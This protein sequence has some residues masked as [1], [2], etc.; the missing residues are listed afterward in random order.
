[1]QGNH[2]GAIHDC[3]AAISRT[4]APAEA[5]LGRTITWVDLGDAGRAIED[6]DAVVK[7]GVNVGAAYSY[8][9][10]ARL[11]ALDFAGAERDGRLGVEAAPTSAENWNVLAVAQLLQG[12]A[13]DALVTATTAATLGDAYALA[14]NTLGVARCVGGDF[15]GGRAALQ[16]AIELDAGLPFAWQNLGVCDLRAHRPASAAENFNWAIER[17]RARLPAPWL[18]LA[19]ASRAANDSEGERIARDVYR[20]LAPTDPRGAAPRDTAPIRGGR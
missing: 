18:G 7:L 11:G 20:E 17:S 15:V 4:D 9:A 1:M 3:D 6:A 2:F 13:A 19:V 5:L 14:W 10:M 8:R 12:R 16:R